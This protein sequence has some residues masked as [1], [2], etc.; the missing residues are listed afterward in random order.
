MR[1]RQFLA[2][3]TSVPLID[4]MS[5]DSPLFHRAILK[6]EA[7]EFNF[8]NFQS[9]LDTVVGSLATFAAEGNLLLQDQNLVPLREGMGGSEPNRFL[10]MHQAKV[11]VFSV[12]VLRRG[13]RAT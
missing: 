13:T 5:Y 8:P 4:A 9:M 7:M 12:S 1:P 11:H 3:I 10:K 6:R 2:K